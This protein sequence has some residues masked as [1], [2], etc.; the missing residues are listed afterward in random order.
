MRTLTVWG[1]GLA[2]MT[3]GEL[4]TLTP[5]SRTAP[6]GVER[7]A[8][9]PIAGALVTDSVVVVLV[10]VGGEEVV[11][12]V[13][14]SD[15]LGEPVGTG[16]RRDGSVGGGLPSEPEPERLSVASCLEVVDIALALAVGS[17]A[18]EVGAGCGKVELP[19]S[20]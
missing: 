10:V 18:E 7:I 5:S 11:V 16:H 4:P 2:L 6:Q 9:R 20:R 3:L 1:P 12:G 19:T 14:A 15:P 17:E 8:S 13:V